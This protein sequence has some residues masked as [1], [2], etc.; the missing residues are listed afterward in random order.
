MEKYIASLRINHLSGSIRQSYISKPDYSEFT[1]F[2][3][4]VTGKNLIIS[5]RVPG[6]LTVHQT[7]TDIYIKRNINTLSLILHEIGHWL[8]ALPDERTHHNLKLL[9]D[10]SLLGKELQAVRE[11]ESLYFE[12]CLCFFIQG[13]E[14]RG[15]VKELEYPEFS[16][17]PAIPTKFDHQHVQDLGSCILDF[18][19]KNP[20]IK[21]L[22]LNLCR[23]LNIN[24]YFKFSDFNSKGN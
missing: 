7:L 18:F 14:Y 16:Y 13:L 12:S 21:N 11:I 8:S 23:K 9:T 4:K 19:G 15:Y 2:C 1:E 3:K 5:D 24:S 6:P 17:I 22:R 10:S 20:K